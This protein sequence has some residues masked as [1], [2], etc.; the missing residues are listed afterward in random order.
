MTMYK[1]LKLSAI[2]AFAL[3]ASG[4]D[5]QAESPFVNMYIGAMGGGSVLHDRG[6]FKNYTT[7]PYKNYH[8]Q[9]YSGLGGGYAGYGLNWGGVITSLEGM[10]FYDGAKTRKNVPPYVARSARGLVYEVGVRAGVLLA[11]DTLLYIRGGASTS[12]I[13]FS[14]KIEDVSRV[15]HRYRPFWVAG[16]GLERIFHT[17]TTGNLIARVEYV[18]QSIPGKY[19]FSAP[20]R[21]GNE[22]QRTDGHIRSHY[23]R[24]GIAKPFSL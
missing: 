1:F 18:Y 17:K 2:S 19:N 10:V 20:G 15:T 6:N 5:A 7:T 8:A 11:S 23:V 14:T 13:K 9:N 21:A 24:L 3:G 4:L 16:G 12:R 22:G